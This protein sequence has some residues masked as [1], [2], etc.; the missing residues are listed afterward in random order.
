VSERFIASHP[1][2]SMH[3]PDLFRAGDRLGVLMF[4]SDTIGHPVV[5]LSHT[6]LTLD[7][8]T[9]PRRVGEE[10]HSWGEAA[11]TGDAVG[12][13]WDGDPGGAGALRFRQVDGLDGDLGPRTDFEPPTGPCTEL[14]YAHGVYGITWRQEHFD[15]EPARV[16]TA[17]GVMTESGELVAEPTMIASDAYPGRSP[18]LVATDDGFLAL[19]HVEDGLRMVRVD[20]RGS[21]VDDR[22]IALSSVSYTA[23]ALRHDRLGLLS[24][25][26]PT[27]TRSLIFRIATLDGRVLVERRI[28]G[29]APTSAYP[30][31]A[32]RPE[33][34]A[35]LWAESS[36]PST[37]AMILSLD[38]DGVPLAP[39][40]PLYD[41]THSGYG[42]PSLLS[43]EESIYVGISHEGPEPPMGREG[44]YVQ[45]W[46]CSAPSED[47]C[48]AQQAQPGDCDGDHVW[49]FRWTGDR[50]APVVGCASD[51][52]GADCDS[53]PSTRIACESDR[54]ECD[55]IACPPTTASLARLCAPAQLSSSASRSI[56]VEI[57]TD[58]CPCTPRP[59]C[60]VEATGERE[61][62]L[63]FEQCA[64][65]VP[66]CE[67]DPTEP[68]RRSL[69]CVL[70]PLAPGDWT[71]R[72]D[73]AEPLTLTAT[74]PW[75]TP[76][77]ALICALE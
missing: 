42:G 43:I 74:P 76:G 67:C 26:G 16:E 49:G 7:D 59:R 27:D 56:D 19:V 21:V 12:V 60:R 24:L 73:G 55:A 5:V 29:G 66:D 33:G 14:V 34:W 13:C 18:S 10:S 20:P 46:E 45:R 61:L 50:C 9:G 57:W 75:E 69:T 41:G 63:S 77:S 17:V 72:A 44:T 39:R 53:L 65:P 48:R 54:A 32:A 62:T 1:D 37:R 64:D 3:A 35:L 47:L 52:I 25:A 15:E 4:Q 70:P 2:G 38:P 22:L 11:W 71:L 40:R 6:D 30:R 68:V 36:R 8:V 28:E 58:G 23:A 31:I 51:C